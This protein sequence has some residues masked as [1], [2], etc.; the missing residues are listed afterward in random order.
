MGKIGRNDSCQCGS[1]KK[2]KNCC[3]NKQRRPS[4]KGK[5]DPYF[6]AMALYGR[7]IVTGMQEVPSQIEYEPAPKD[8]SLRVLL[9]DFFQNS[10]TTKSPKVNDIYLLR[11]RKRCEKYLFNDPKPFV[12]RIMAPEA[13]K[14]QCIESVRLGCSIY[15]N[16]IDQYIFYFR[17]KMIKH[18]REI[19]LRFLL[20]DDD[21][22]IA[23]F[24][25]RQL[26]ELACHAIAC[27]WVLS[28]AY[29]VIRRELD[30]T[31]DKPCYV[32]CKELEDFVIGLT[33]WEKSQLRK[34]GKFL[35]KTFDIKKE[36]FDQSYKPSTR[37]LI[38]TAEW[39]ADNFDQAQWADDKDLKA[40]LK[41]LM[42]YYDFS[43]K[44]IH[45][46]PMLFE[47]DDI[48]E[49][50]FRYPTKDD[51]LTSS[52]IVFLQVLEKC[53]ILI[54]NLFLKHIFLD[55]SFSKMVMTLIASSKQITNSR[56]SIVL[57]FIPKFVSRSRDSIIELRNDDGTLVK[58]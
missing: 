17:I 6:R 16:E 31:S 35:G 3:L 8:Q 9:D 36:Y 10:L 12:P 47:I 42:E 18:L 40:T 23:F 11:L 20:L 4:V 55:A 7:P 28:T 14:E 50:T 25:I 56:A 33:F 22:V 19:I 15:W 49:G 2:Y 5:E 57:D 24:T 58:I 48:K 39:V 32:V 41:S 52:K 13:Y 46:T 37:R 29:N 44:F 45:P 38:Q 30:K 26:I 51:V 34:L 27:Q 1:G 54:D 53:D 43:C 21:Y